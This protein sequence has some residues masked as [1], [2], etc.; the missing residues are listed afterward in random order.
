MERGWAGLPFRPISEFYKE[1]FGEKTYKIPVSIAGDCP[2]RQGLKGM[3]TCSFCD[4]WGSAAREQSL[5]MELQDQISHYKSIIRKSKNANK[6]LVYFQAYTSTFQDLASL[7]RA[8]ELA[9]QDPEVCGLVI[10][11]RPDCVSPAVMKLW[12]RYHE[13]IGFVSVE[14]GVQSFDEE[15]LLFYRRGHTAKK[16][17]EVIRKIREN[18]SVDLGVHLIL[19]APRDTAAEAQR[20]AE[21]CNSLDISNV[22]LHNLHVLKNTHL[23][24]LWNQGEFQAISREEYAQLVRIFLEHL[25]PQI[26]VHRL[27]AYSS[28]WDE[29]IAPKWTADKMGTH[30]A[31]VDFLRA[32]NSVQGLQ[33]KP[34]SERQVRIR[35]DLLNRQFKITTDAPKNP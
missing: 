7:E 6:F 11:T 4:V 27:A 13:K 21:I 9:S 30:Q 29:L 15:T 3:K 5:T 17:Q 16:S 28:R 23:E 24:T 8:F 18:T 25:D 32:E 14:M 10:G 22:K 2:N 12:Q 20:M 31:L 26:Y 35:Q 33:F 1:K 34:Q 19:G